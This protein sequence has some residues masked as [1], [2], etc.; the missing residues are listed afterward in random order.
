MWY[1]LDLVDYYALV[2][3]FDRVDGMVDMIDNGVYVLVF[4]Y[5]VC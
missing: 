3:M 5:I 1:I 4:N 2:F